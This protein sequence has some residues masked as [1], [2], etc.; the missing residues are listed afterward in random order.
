M[1]RGGLVPHAPADCEPPTTPGE[2]LAEAI[3][4]GELRHIAPD[5]SGR[6]D[7]Q[8][9]THRATQTG[10]LALEPRATIV[11]ER[12]DPD[13]HQ[14]PQV[15]REQQP[16]LE[17]EPDPACAG[18]L[19]DSEDARPVLRVPQIELGARLGP[20]QLSALDVEN[21]RVLPE[22]LARDRQP[23]P[24]APRVGPPSSEDSVRRRLQH[25]ETTPPGRRDLGTQLRP[26]ARL[27]GRIP[28]GRGALAGWFRG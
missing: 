7:P 19:V 4:E 22:I 24:H 10:G 12:G 14:A 18:E 13:P 20:A 6:P 16:V 9:H 15:L 5:R 11:E 27:A 3:S 1:D 26:D 28:P 25:R 17:R 23:R 2:P 8:R 21:Q